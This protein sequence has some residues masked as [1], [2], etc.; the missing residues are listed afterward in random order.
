[1]Q[2]LF[3]FT[4]KNLNDQ[5]C[6]HDE[7][8]DHSL[9]EYCFLGVLNSKSG[10]IALHPQGLYFIQS[11]LSMFQKIQVHEEKNTSSKRIS[12]HCVP[13]HDAS[14]LLRAGRTVSKGQQEWDYR[15]DF[16]I[17]HHR[18]TLHDFPNIAWFNGSKIPKSMH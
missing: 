11:F 12:T 8:I 10:D 3:L 5:S 17:L 16:Y 4:W 9:I 14:S 18:S 13:H 6:F 15:L 1:M 2:R 7:L